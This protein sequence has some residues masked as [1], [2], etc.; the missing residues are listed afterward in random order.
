MARRLGR[1]TRECQQLRE[2]PPAGVSCWPEGDNLDVF[3][4][5]I[6][7]D[8]DSVYSGG[9]FRLEVEVPERY[10]F[11]PPKIRFLTKIY[12]PNID[13][14]GRICLD[15]LKLP[16]SG[17]WR[18]AHNLASVLS[19]IRLLMSDPNPND[20]LMTEIAEEYQLQKSQYESTARDW[21]VK[22]AKNFVV[23]KQDEPQS[24]AGKRKAES[25]SDDEAR[26]KKVKT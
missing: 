18:P 5:E 17:S 26:E 9:M 7:G 21:T 4:A 25:D 22:Y 23:N 12:H 3:T 6:V 19:S 20:P 24:S 14:A 10:P 8:E 11:L 15:I 2:S 13:S 16:P 1:L